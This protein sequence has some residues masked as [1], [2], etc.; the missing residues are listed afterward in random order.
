MVTNPLVIRRT[1][2]IDPN[3]ARVPT[4][5]CSKERAAVF[6]YR[7]TRASSGAFAKGAKASEACETGR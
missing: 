3:E 2:W 7:A 5:A 1:A 4:A 6:R